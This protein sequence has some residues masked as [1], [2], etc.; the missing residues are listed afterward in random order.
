MSARTW[1]DPLVFLS[2]VPQGDG[3]VGGHVGDTTLDLGLQ[4]HVTLG[5]VSKE[6]LCNLSLLPG[7]IGYDRGVVQ[8]STYKQQTNIRYGTYS[9]SSKISPETYM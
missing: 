4:P 8:D 2:V 9:V 6:L 3:G 5:V 1:C 7:W